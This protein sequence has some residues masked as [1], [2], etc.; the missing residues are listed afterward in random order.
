MNIDTKTPGGTTGFSTNQNAVNRWHIN[1]SYRAAVRNCF[2]DFLG[3]RSQKHLRH[4]LRPSRIQ[5]DERDV[6]KLI[7]I[8]TEG[9]IDPFSKNELLCLSN[10]MLATEKVRNDLLTAK[11]K[12]EESM[13]TFIKNRLLEDAKMSMFDPIKKLNLG[14]FSKMMKTVKVSCKDKQVPL[15]ATRNLFGQIAIIMQNRNL[16]LKDIFQYPLGPFPWALAGQSGELKKT[17]KVA[18][19]HA[20]E[21][22]VD[23]V[24]EYPASHV[25][26]IDFFFLCI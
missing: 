6:E 13:E 9:F 12:G 4:D 15:E 11:E 17:N 8:L 2:N 3:Q 21:K 19:L 7:Q 25:C 16:D 14:T 20:L 24:E 5:R 26:I 1:A 22:D 23:P 10:G 18:L